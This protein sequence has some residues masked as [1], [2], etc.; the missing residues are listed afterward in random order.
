VYFVTTGKVD[1]G[2]WQRVN[3]VKASF[4]PTTCAHWEHA[5]RLID[6]AKGKS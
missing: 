4:R 1:D 5:I 2:Y 6:I 3:R